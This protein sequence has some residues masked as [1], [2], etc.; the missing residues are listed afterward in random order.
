[1]MG[2]LGCSRHFINAILVIKA[3]PSY[4]YL[5]VWPSLLDACRKRGNVE[6]GRLAF[7]QEALQLD[8]TCVVVYVVL[9][10]NLFSIS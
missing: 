5:V 1:M 3:M 4:D 6:F 2:V 7:D 8:T 9:M 10:S